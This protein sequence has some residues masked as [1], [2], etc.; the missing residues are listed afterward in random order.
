MG[1]FER[2]IMEKRWAQARVARHQQ[3]LFQS[4]ED[5]LGSSD[6]IRSLDACLDLV[7]WGP[8]ELRY[9]GHRGQ[10]P[11]HPKLL[12][13]SILYGLMRGI[14]SSREL[15]DA[16]RVRLDFMW[17][18][19]G[20]TIDHSTF[21][22]FR[23][24]FSVFLKDLNRCIAGLICSRY[25]DSLLTLVIDGTRIRAN[26]DRHGARTAET[27]S[28]LIDAC[29]REL[30][31]KLARLEQ[32]DARES[33]T[34]EQVRQLESEIEGLRAKLAKYERAYSVAQSRDEVKQKIEGKSATAVRVP[35]T[36]P[37][38]MIVPNKEGGYAPN[39][40]PTVAVDQASGAIVHCEVQRG[41][42]ESAAVMQ[43]VGE[44]ETMGKMPQRILADSGF[45]SGE[46][47]H[48]L[49]DK[50]IEAYMPT[51]TD[52]RESNP[53]NRVDPTQ[54]VP[55][56][57]WPQLPRRGGKLARS[58][59]LYDEN[60]DEYRCPMGVALT[61]TRA[62]KSGK[63]GRFCAQYNC[64]GKEGC[65]LADECVKK[66]ASARIITRDAY[67]H[68]REKMGRRMA[69][70]LGRAV[71]KSRAPVVEGA[72]GGLKHGMGI[73]RFLLRGLEK[74][75][76]EWNWICIA[77]NLKI[78]VRLTKRNPAKDWIKSTKTSQDNRPSK[79]QIRLNPIP[80]LHALYRPLLPFK[81]KRAYNL[82]LAA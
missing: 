26:S 28:R 1:R 54:P 4:L 7:D 74:V 71:Y 29:A 38:S 48:S 16:T 41:S 3:F 65:P 81:T 67:Q 40:T 55:Q 77:Y 69:T 70:E 32:V 12:A 33:E 59:F 13:G 78:F 30:D 49:E 46:N 10:P 18:L 39:Y 24:Q 73:R 14:R 15:E 56:A 34:A 47:L 6:P 61:R 21:A 36:D 23:T 44:A 75:R 9:L 57:Q 27:L 2:G 62:G 42:E 72:I 58:A 80:F 19:E 53:A 64:P 11:I 31:G 43:A 50:K 22:D 51:D 37:D 79:A 8:W 63:D 82:S 45:A 52:F 5:L 60:K 20:R 17:F 76:T 68:L 35:V 25:E 66:K